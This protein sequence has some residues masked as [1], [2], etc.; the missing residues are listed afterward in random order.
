M[1]WE[2]AEGDRPYALSVGGVRGSALLVMCVVMMAVRVAKMCLMRP[3]EGGR[4]EEGGLRDIKGSCRRSRRWK[5]REFCIARLNA[6]VTLRC[7]SFS[8][9]LGRVFS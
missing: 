8:N 5:G 6:E 1:A 2:K 3:G 4:V 9:H 7:F